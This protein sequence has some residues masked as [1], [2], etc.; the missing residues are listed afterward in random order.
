MQKDD[1]IGEP[2]KLKVLN[3]LLKVKGV[4]Q[5][6]LINRNG[7]IITCSPSENE[8]LL[9]LIIKSFTTS[10]RI[11]IELFWGYLNQCLLEYETNKI[12]MATVTDKIFVIVTDG[13]AAIGTVR[14]NMN[15][16]IEV[17]VK[18]L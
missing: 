1:D 18:I 13:N 14:H 6:A 17:L 7:S 16:A 9:R 10:E 2:E 4:V 3:N 5:S 12:L 11:G 8:D 15:K